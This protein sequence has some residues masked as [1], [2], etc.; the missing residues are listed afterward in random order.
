MLQKLAKK[1]LVEKDRP[2]IE[3]GSNGIVT[4]T[5]I[6]QHNDVGDSEFEKVWVTSF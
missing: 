2:D 3:S 6:L 1:K 5:Q 4:L